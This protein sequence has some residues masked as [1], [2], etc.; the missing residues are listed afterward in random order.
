MIGWFALFSKIK[1]AFIYS[2]IGCYGSLL[3]QIIVN[4]MLSRLLIPD[5]FG[6]F[7][8]ATFFISFLRIFL[9]SGLGIAIIQSK[10][11]DKDDLG[12]LFIFSLIFSIL[13]SVIFWMY[14][15][16]YCWEIILFQGF[17]IF[18]VGAKVVPQAVLNKEERFKELNLVL[19]F[20]SFF[21]GIVG[22][23]F[24]FFGGSIYSLFVINLLD[25][26]IGFVCC[27]YLTKSTLVRN[28][29]IGIG[30][31]KKIWHFCVTNSLVSLV[32]FLASNCEIP[33]IFKYLGSSAEANFRKVNL[34]CVLPNLLLTNIFSLILLP[35]LSNFQDDVNLIKNIYFKI[36]HFITLIGFPLSIFFSFSSKQI[37][38]VFFGE[39]W[40][41]AVIPFAI[42]I[43]ILGVNAVAS[44]FGRSVFQIFEKNKLFIVYSYS[45]AVLICGLKFVGIFL[46]KLTYLAV[47]QN[48]AYFCIFCIGCI[49]L[50]KYI[51]YTTLLSLLKEFIKP[52]LFGGIMSIIFFIYQT[53]IGDF[54]NDFI[55]LVIKS[56]LFLGTM[57][58]LVFCLASDEMRNI[59]KMFRR[60]KNLKK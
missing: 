17:S 24:A 31:L 37:I 14:F 26:L 11:L 32:Y 6:L 53:F 44:I 34:L 25:N 20:S 9:D 46:G 27:V 39:Q 28:F 49:I 60:E 12:S 51:F 59:K 15:D 57:T 45:S 43:L 42:A 8:Y 48:I 36:F 47:M 30:V 4:M 41:E 52:I 18:F 56:L 33:L 40:S 22:V 16:F 21:S 38:F 29:N 58:I 23:S 10:K 35:I 7:D 54:K 55:S 50:C 3:V 5:K 19:L 13:I 1:F 2:L